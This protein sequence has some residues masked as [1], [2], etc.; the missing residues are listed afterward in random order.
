MADLFL[1]IVDKNGQI[2]SEAT[3]AEWVTLVYPKSYEEGDSILL[4]TSEK[5]L[6]IMWQVDD[7][8]GTAMCYLTEDVSY[9]IP[10]GEKKKVYSPKAFSGDKHYLYA[11]VATLE[12]VAQYRNLATNVADQHDVKGCYPHASAN[13]ETR[14]E[15]VFAARNA[16][17]GVYAN[18]YHGRWPYESWG[19]NR[20]PNAEMKIEFG[21][22]VLV[23]K[24][25]IVLRADFPHDSYW[26]EGTVRFSDGSEEVL[27]FVKTD[28]GQAF[29][30]KPRVIEW[31]TFGKLIKAEDESPFPALTQMEVYGIEAELRIDKPQ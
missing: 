7:A 30:I 18:H 29:A 16:I 17:D 12:E 2:L 27:K 21:R 8:L 4:S 3:G 24:L 19:I 1:R 22:K 25:V 26:T 6:H 31:L 28:R 13:V 15:S 20:D 11:R 5:N 23:D 14:G 10:F 9:A